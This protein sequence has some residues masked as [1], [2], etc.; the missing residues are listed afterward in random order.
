MIFLTVLI[1][2]AVLALYIAAVWW[3]ATK[4]TDNDME[5]A[6]FVLTVTALV[7]VPIAA[8]V[9]CVGLQP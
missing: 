2:F 8:I 9:Q 3:A 6:S 4:L 1:G 7:G 5:L